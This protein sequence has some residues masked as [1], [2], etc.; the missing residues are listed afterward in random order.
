ME[1]LLLQFAGLP[2]WQ[3][4]LMASWLL[5]VACV[6]PS[7][8]EEIV[9]T[10]LGMLWGRG[11][12]GFMEAFIAVLAGLL[13][14]NL[15]SVFIGSLLA[16][17]FSLWDPLA[18]PLRS[19]A[20]QAALGAIRRHGRAVVL[21]TRFTPLVRGPVYLAAGLSRM[22]LSRFLQVDAPAACLQVPLLLWFGARVG[23]GAGSLVE[24]W[25][26]MGWLALGLAV[27]ML[28]LHVL[29][30]HRRPRF[31]CPTTGRSPAPEGAKPREGRA[32]E[33]GVAPL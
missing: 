27:A 32:G 6:I 9:I 12:I 31:G 8:P 5:L 1:Q 18:R 14:A 16:R 28:A 11:R 21:V 20:V 30:A 15:G 25:G 29:L 22:S 10:T 2:S 24:A 19:A 23:D 17:G 7:V 3:I 4:V 13:A 26:R 33:R